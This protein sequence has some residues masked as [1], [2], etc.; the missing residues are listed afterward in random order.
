MSER[1]SINMNTTDV[2]QKYREKVKNAISKREKELLSDNIDHFLIYS[3][4]GISEP[5]SIQIDLYQNIGRIVYKNAGALIEDTVRQ[6]FPFSQKIK[7]P[8]N[9][10]PNPKTFEIDCLVDNTAI[11]IKWRD[12]TTDGDHIQKEKNRLTSIALHGYKP[13]RLMFFEPNRENAKKIQR[14]LKELYLSHN[15][16]YYSGKEAWDYVKRETGRDLYKELISQ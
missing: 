1:Q 6:C 11:E 10:S 7:I 4:L 12:S 16:E 14:K 2:V 3:L 5:Q 15:G 8:N 9:I 13:V